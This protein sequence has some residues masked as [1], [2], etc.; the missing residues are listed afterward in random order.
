MKKTLKITDLDYSFRAHP[1]TGNLMLKSGADAIKQSVKTLVLL[2]M[3]EKP[4]STISGNITNKLFNDFNYALENQTKSDIKKLLEIYEKRV[5][6][7]EVNLNVNEN[8]LN[9][10]IIYTILGED[11]P[12]QEVSIEVTRSR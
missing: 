10:S 4:F 8:T 9:I 11:V 7:T 3:F 6:V 2:N 12:E 5:E 1:V